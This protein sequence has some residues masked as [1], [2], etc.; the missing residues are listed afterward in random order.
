MVLEN[1]QNNKSLGND[2]IQVEFYKK[3]WSLLS[4]P[5]TKC[6]NECFETGEMSA[7]ITLIEK[8]GKDRLL[9]ENW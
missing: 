3:F 1:F 9:L 6:V 8:K 5:F 4:E 7:V 2:G